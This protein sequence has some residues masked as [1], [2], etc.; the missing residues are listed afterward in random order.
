MFFENFFSS[1]S[2]HTERK[3]PTPTF[4][5]IGGARPQD[6][7]RLEDLKRLCQQY[8]S[9][10]KLPTGDESA[11]KF[12]VNIPRSE[13]REMLGRALC[14][15]HTMIDEHFGIGIV[16]MMAAGLITIAHNSGGPRSD[17]IGPCGDGWFLFYQNLMFST[18]FFVMFLGA[19]SV[20]KLAI[21]EDEYVQAI[22]SSIELYQKSPQEI[23]SLVQRARTR[24][25]RMFSVEAFDASLA[26]T[27]IPALRL[28][29]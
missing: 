8:L 14:G 11:I 27:L 12:F 7:Q 6:Q 10:A 9:E 23:D 17:I 2:L 28:K 29:P 3:L 5:L 16:E 1:L 24:S 22:V 13:L 20:G 25:T 18:H 19:Q 15:I 26:K 21:T 4:A